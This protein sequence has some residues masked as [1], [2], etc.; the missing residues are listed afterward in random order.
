[1]MSETSRKRKAG[2]I[3]LEAF[4]AVREELDR[5]EAQLEEREEA[6]RKATEGAEK[7]TQLMAGRQPSDV[8]VLNIGGTRCHVLRKTLCQY[9]KSMLAAHFSGRWEDWEDS[10]EKDADGCYFLDQPPELM[11]PLVDYLRAK[12]IET[13]KLLKGPPQGL[14]EDRDFWRMVEYYGMTPFVFQQHFMLRRGKKDMA[15][16]GHSVEPTATCTGWCTML[17]QPAQH[18]RHVSSFTVVLGS[19]IERPQIGWACH[20]YFDL[21]LQVDDHKGVGEEKHTIALDAVRRGVQCGGS[22][23]KDVPQLILQPGSVI[24]CGLSWVHDGKPTY[25]WIVDG[26]VVAVVS[27]GE[28]SARLSDSRLRNASVSKLRP[29][30]SGKGHWHVSHY[31]YL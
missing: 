7:K 18:S 19:L 21:K 24:T 30:I 26:H 28:I 9:E 5:R 3:L 25:R 1:M 23:F 10:V 8:L 29:A 17:L 6:L 14:A 31:E 22:S 27:G 16:T 20:D 4:D 11:M 13:P 15:V 12:A 2:D